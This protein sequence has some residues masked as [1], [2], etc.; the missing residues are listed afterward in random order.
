MP[1]LRGLLRLE[2]AVKIDRYLRSRDAHAPPSGIATRLLI[3]QSQ[4]AA[5]CRDA[6]APPSGIAT[7]IE[8]ATSTPM[9]RRD[10]HAPPSGIATA[11]G[12][13][14]ADGAGEASR[15]PCPAFGDCYS[16]GGSPPACPECSCRDAHAPPSGIATSLGPFPA[17]VQVNRSRRPC[18][19]FGDCYNPMRFSRI[20]DIAASRRPCPAFGDCYSPL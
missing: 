15:R 9:G 20:V 12:Q 14:L 7:G 10:A 5:A 8:P 2:S 16:G 11:V 18:P 6:H 4:L 19:A 13:G 1:R 17:V 3:R